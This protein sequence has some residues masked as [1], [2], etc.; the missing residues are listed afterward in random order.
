MDF[1]SFVLA[2]ST[3]DLADARRP[4]VRSRADL[5]EYRMDLAENPLATLRRYDGDVPVLA[6][7]RPV[8]E[9]GE[10][11]DDGTRLDALASAIECDAVDAVDV[12]LATIGAGTADAVLETARR[13]DVSVVVSVHDFEGTPS[14]S[15]LVDLLADAAGHGDVA[16]LAVTASSPADALALLAATDEATRT[17]HTVATMAMG[18]VGTHTRVVAPIYGSKLG[19]APVDADAATAPGQLDLET[20][21][22]L[23]A[24]VR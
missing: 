15:T 22:S 5:L 20:L 1:E 16:K 17:G 11:S 23:I 6:T 21:A 13:H 2:A 19:Y 12:E 9:G 7:N 14:A 3:G 4:V 8:W 24:A 18:E 10:A